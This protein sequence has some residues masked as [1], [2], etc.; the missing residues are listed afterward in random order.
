MTSPA[1][2]T[3]PLVAPGLVGKNQK[4]RGPRKD[5]SYEVVFING[6][7]NS[8][9][10]HKVSAGGVAAVSGGKVLGVFN[11]SSGT[12]LDL[13]QCVADKTTY[14][15]NLRMIADGRPEDITAAWF[16][17]TGQ[18]DAPPSRE[19]RVY[20][21][22]GL[23]NKATAELF[24][25]L[26]NTIAG[27]VRI[28]AHSQGNL[29]TC[30]ALLALGI[31]TSEAEVLNKVK[32]YAVAPPDF[33][34]PKGFP[35]ESFEFANDGVP[36]IGLQ[37]GSKAY[38][39]YEVADSRKVLGVGGKVVDSPEVNAWSPAPQV[40]VCTP[41]VDYTFSFSDACADVPV[42]QLHHNFFI[43]LEAYW[44]EFKTCFP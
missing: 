20:K 6:I 33:S 10:D 24:W 29:I 13:L 27:E 16:L 41:E 32:V 22:L 35:T 40:W 36:W 1:I 15:S 39:L 44:Y 9:L 17:A 28:M 34:W 4:S 7:N 14:A 26:L 8:P 5:K 21:F 2:S 18:V 30:V 19:T 43:Y 25:H 23:K 3:F 31:V 38:R 11:Q 12:L 42:P 37:F